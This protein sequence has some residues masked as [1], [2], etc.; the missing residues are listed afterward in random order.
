MT[1]KPVVSKDDPVALAICPA[2]K[3]SAFFVLE[4]YVSAEDKSDLAR[5][6]EQ[7]YQITSKALSKASSVEECQCSPQKIAIAQ[8][9]APPVPKP[10]GKPVLSL[11]KA[12]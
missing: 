5:L 11:R 1:F 7:G 2:C 12:K 8:K 4:K 3:G 6:G 9:P 10:T